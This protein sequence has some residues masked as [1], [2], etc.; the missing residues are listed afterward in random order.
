MTLDL[1]ERL[2]QS[3][4]TTYAIDREI[5]SG[6][7]RVFTADEVPLGRRVV[8]KVL[9]PELAAAVAEDRFEDEMGRATQ[10]DDPH[11]VRILSAGDTGGLPFYIML[12]VDGES[13]RSRLARGPVPVADAVSILRDVALALQYAHEKGVVHG[14]IG[15]DHVRLTRESAVVTDFG[16][17]QAIAVS[18]GGAAL[19]TLTQNGLSGRTPAYMAPEQALGDENPDH[20]VDIYAWGMMAYELLAGR[21]PFG[22]RSTPAQAMV[23]AQIAEMPAPLDPPP[24]RTPRGLASL[25]DE[26]LRKNPADRP[27]NAGELLRRLGEDAPVA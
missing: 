26:C 12:F 4:G 9:N 23:A 16:V 17:A 14:D 15:P 24:G 27:P 19:T 21:H 8:L 11:I 10:L 18:T 22:G 2:Q 3:V 13:L 25:V 6:M 20:R 7:S 1:R 5:E